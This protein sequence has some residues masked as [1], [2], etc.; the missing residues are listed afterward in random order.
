MGYNYVASEYIHSMSNILSCKN[1]SC[2]VHRSYWRQQDVVWGL[3][4]VVIIVV[5]Y[6]PDAGFTTKISNLNLVRAT[7]GTVQL[8]FLTV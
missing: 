3:C 8:L 2:L 1:F 7:S 5:N 6:V 4:A